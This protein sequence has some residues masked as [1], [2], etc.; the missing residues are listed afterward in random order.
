MESTIGTDEVNLWVGCCSQG[1][2][3]LIPQNYEFFVKNLEPLYLNFLNDRASGV[4][5][6]G[7]EGIEVFAKLFGDQWINS[8][9][10]R[11]EEILGK[12]TSYHFKIA[13]IY[14]LK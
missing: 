1:N 6:V 9:I 10:P 12:E 13:A 3:V 5:N 4:R 2:Y 14:S 8:F 7:I 11:L